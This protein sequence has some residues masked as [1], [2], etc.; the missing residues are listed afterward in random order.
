MLLPSQNREHQHAARLLPRT[1]S[2]RD[3]H[4]GDRGKEETGNDMKD[5]E[6]DLGAILIRP[7]EG[8]SYADVM[9]A[10]KEKVNSTAS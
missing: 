3:S 10:I 7:E 2:Q 8:K 9:K 1:A 6:E 4:P 5:E